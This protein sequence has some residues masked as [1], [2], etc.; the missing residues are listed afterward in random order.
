MRMLAP[1]ERSVDRMALSL[2]FSRAEHISGN[3]PIT[4]TLRTLRPLR[5]GERRGEIS[6]HLWWD[7]HGPR[8]S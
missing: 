6:T 5:A 4:R 7:T 2:S 1:L 8:R 3:N